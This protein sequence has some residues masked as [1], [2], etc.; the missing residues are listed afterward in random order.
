VKIIAVGSPKGGV[1][2]TTTAVTLAAIAGRAG[3]R[4]LLVDG[5]E[6]RSAWDWAGAAGDE[7]PVDVHATSDPR[8]LAKLRDADEYDLMV[9]DLPGARVGAFEAVLTGDGRLP[10]PDLLLVPTVPEVLDLRPVLRVVR[11]EVIPLELP[12]LV[13]LTKVPTSGLP[14]ARQQRSLVLAAGAGY[15]F[16]ETIIRRYSAFDEAVEANLTV[17]D[18]GGVGSRARLAEADYR[19]LA[20]EALPLVGIELPTDKEAIR[21]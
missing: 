12:H 7:I 16:A 11:E 21:G 4:V 2:K 20:D 3:L 1:A 19:Q 18:L 6:N 17:L 10:V 13:V 14:R 5:D 9:V 8:E 15:R